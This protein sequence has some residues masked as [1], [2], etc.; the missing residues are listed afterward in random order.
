MQIRSRHRLERAYQSGGMAQGMGWNLQF[1][2]RKGKPRR[3]HRSP[4]LC[5]A[6]HWP[7]PH[8]SFRRSRFSDGEAQNTHRAGKHQLRDRSHKSEISAAQSPHFQAARL[9]EGGS[10]KRYAERKKL[11]LRYAALK[12][13]VKE[14]EQIRKGVYS[15]LREENRKEQPAHKQDLCSWN[16]ERRDG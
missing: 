8:R 11:S 15:I 3:T 10:G 5:A 12:D 4:Q 9:A 13:E 16:A 1:V 14:A 2:S 6:R 7:N